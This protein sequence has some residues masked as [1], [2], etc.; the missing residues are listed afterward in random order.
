MVGEGGFFVGSVLCEDDAP[1][2]TSLATRRAFAALISPFTF[3]LDSFKCFNFSLLEVRED[4]SVIPRGSR[5]GNGG[6]S[7]FGGSVGS[8]FESVF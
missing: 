3:V 1:R 8:I 2:M 7:F 6:T 4:C 5:M